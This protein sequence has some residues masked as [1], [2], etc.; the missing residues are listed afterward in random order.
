MPWRKKWQPTPVF[1]PGKSH[2]HGNLAGYSPWDCKESDMTEHAHTTKM[3]KYSVEKTLIIKANMA[4][5]E[6]KQNPLISTTL[7]GGF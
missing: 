2:G 5:L 6:Q 3:E 1:L 7:W 4:C